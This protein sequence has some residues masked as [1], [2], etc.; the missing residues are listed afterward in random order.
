MWLPI[1]GS[2]AGL[3][4]SCWRNDRPA[5]VCVVFGA[6]H[7][8]PPEQRRYHL[9][10]DGDHTERGNVRFERYNQ[11][12]ERWRVA[13]LWQPSGAV[14]RIHSQLLA[15]MRRAGR[16]TFAASGGGIAANAVA[17]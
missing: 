4:G 11:L 6:I 7:G 8:R 2:V 5:M 10:E 14:M 13:S 17:L 1:G 16:A 9:R 15:R 3:S 12:G